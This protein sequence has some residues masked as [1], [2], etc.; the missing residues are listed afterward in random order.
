MGKTKRGSYV[1]KGETDFEKFLEGKLIP[2]FIDIAKEDDEFLAG[3]VEQGFGGVRNMT[4]PELVNEYEAI[5]QTDPRDD[6][7]NGGGE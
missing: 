5:F 2:A 4:I 1:K 7:V 3:M 6:F